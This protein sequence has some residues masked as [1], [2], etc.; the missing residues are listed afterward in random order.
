MPVASR[1]F[2]VLLRGEKLLDAGNEAEAVARAGATS[3]LRV[4]RHWN[5]VKPQAKRDLFVVLWRSA[6][7]D[8]AELARARAARTQGE[9][10][11]LVLPDDSPWESLLE[12][13][14][15]LNIR[16]AERVHVPR[17]ECDRAETFL[18]R[19][20][21]ALS[22]GDDHDAIADAWWEADRL[23]ILSPTFERIKVPLEALPKLGGASLEDRNAFEIDGCGE[24]I[25]WPR[26]DVHMGW[27][28]FMQAADPQ[29]R[30][31]AQGRSDAF[32]RAYGRAIR[33]HR[34]EAGLT[35]SRIAGLD[36]RTVRRIEL[37]TTRVTSNA[38]AKLARAHRMSANDYLGELANRL[39]V[40]APQT[41]C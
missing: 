12:A 41:G 28:Q 2:D 25:Y 37:G 11:F 21:A 30:L 3:W 38:L 1:R 16:S 13:I 6:L 5:Q 36:E 34:E 27:S 24:Y 20:L 4:L 40:A 8:E 29:A 23:V 31:R 14:F 18:R 22:L 26:H 10:R 9:K 32:N 35:Q 17:L 33:T 7:F 15:K 19:F 39:D